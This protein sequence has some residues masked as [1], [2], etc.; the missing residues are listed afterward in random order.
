MYLDM[1]YQKRETFGLY[2]ALKILLRPNLGA[3]IY[4]IG[5]EFQTNSIVIIYKMRCDFT[6]N[7]GTLYSCA[8]I[9]LI[10]VLK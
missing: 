8:K 1:L 9:P 10:S 7:I 5:N 3:Y 2:E 6:L 4:E